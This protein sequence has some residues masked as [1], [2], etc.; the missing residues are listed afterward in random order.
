MTPLRD[1]FALFA[2]VLSLCLGLAFAVSVNRLHAKAGSEEQ[3]DVLSIGGSVTEIVVALGQQHRLKARDTT[4]VYPEDITALPDV[5]YMR[6]LSS[7]GILSVA[8]GLILSEEGAGPPEALDVIRGAD[9][10]FVE[11]P[12]AVDGDGIAAKI[13]AVAKVLNVPERGETLAAEVRESLAAAEKQ[14]KTASD[15][16]HRVMFVLSAQDGRIVAAGQDTEADA[17]I[18]MAGGINAVTDVSG[19]KQLSDEAI[20]LASPDVVLMMDRR[21]NHAISDEAL[22]ELPAMRLTPAAKTRSIIRMNGLL[23]LGF[24]PR[25]AEAVAELHRQLYADGS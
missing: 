13:M 10:S 16:A 24:G 19:Y 17:I 22:L 21:G 5:G 18:R 6:A 14:A 7:E 2:T 9:I 4:S 11:I 23:L 1:N 20:G 25:T 8:P 12:S 15:N 3:A